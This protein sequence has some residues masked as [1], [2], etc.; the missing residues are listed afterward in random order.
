MVLRK[1]G[2]IRPVITL[3]VGLVMLGA[4]VLRSSD[5]ASV[6]TPPPAVVTESFSI[7]AGGYSNVVLG[8]HPA[9][10][11]IAGP[12]VFIPCPSLGL[13][14][15]DVT[16]NIQDDIDGLSYGRDFIAAADLPVTEFSVAAGSQGVAG[17]AVRVEKSCATAEPQA[18]AFETA[19]TGTN[20]QDLDGDGVPCGANAGLPLGLCEVGCGAAPADE[21]DA[22]QQNPSL[23]DTNGDG[24]LDNPVYFT[25]TPSSPSLSDPA[26]DG[27]DPGGDATSADILVTTGPG[28]VAVW[29]DGAT[30]LGLNEAGGDVIDAVCLRED[31]DGVFGAT[32]DLLFSLAPGSPTLAALGASAADL[33]RPGPAVSYTAAKLGL[34]PSDNLD[35]LKCPGDDTDGDTIFDGSDNCPTVPNANQ[36]NADGDEYGDACEQPQ[37][38][39]VVNHWTVPNGDSDCDGFPDT[40][41]ASGRAPESFIGTDAAR[42][43]AST[44][45]P[46]DEPLPDAWP[47]DFNDDQLVGLVDV[48]MYSSHFGAH[49]SDPPGT[50]PSYAQRFDLNGDGRIT[51]PDV[52]LF[53][54]FF[55]KRCAP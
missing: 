22:L 18:D 19:Y 4:I 12:S 16:T 37:C 2:S 10:I 24:L 28:T 43:C 51:L 30:Q 6:F 44:S 55:G 9:D 21:L 5:T 38:V 29:A 52:S 31:G 3:A 32:D 46:N 50:I 35:A 13:T 8:M 36:A 34:M 1:L 41:A 20:A 42:K 23:V 49:A 40:V 53:S 48:S 47:M 7:K 45:M 25:L 11:L 17:S 26:V 54:S 33:L 27:T 14:C 15:T 39:T